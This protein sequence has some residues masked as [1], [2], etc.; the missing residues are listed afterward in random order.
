MPN[1]TSVL[2]AWIIVSLAGA[3]EVLFSVTV[4]QS[5]GYT[6]LLPSV[7]SIGAAILSVWLMSLTL[8]ALPLGTVYAVWAG[9][10]AVG[11]AVIGVILFGEPAN[12]ARIACVAAIV[13]GIVGLQM[14]SAG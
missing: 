1:I 5:E 2:T 12:L 3:L 6:R 8:K 14:Q 9:I 4:K 7:V 13:V 11:T 10:G